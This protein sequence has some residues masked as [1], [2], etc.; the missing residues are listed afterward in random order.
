MELLSKVFVAG[1]TAIVHRQFLAN[2]SYGEFRGAGQ[3]K[4]QLVCGKLFQFPDGVDAEEM[5]G[6]PCFRIALEHDI[7]W[8]IN[9]D[10]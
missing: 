6:I 3:P 10:P 7:Q 1:K 4:Y 8:R 2:S 9:G 5:E